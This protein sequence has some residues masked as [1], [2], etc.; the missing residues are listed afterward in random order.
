MGQTLRHLVIAPNEEGDYSIPDGW[1]AVAAERIIGTEKLDV[2][3]MKTERV[4]MDQLID[5]KM[6]S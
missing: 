4:N 2:I 1:E 6:L 3:V 5:T